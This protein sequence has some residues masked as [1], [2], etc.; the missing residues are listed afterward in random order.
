MHSEVFS[1]MQ[2]VVPVTFSRPDLHAERLR[3]SL[4]DI[5]AGIFMSGERS[6]VLFKTV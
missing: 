1:K 5:S 4:D 2:A 6:F 3:N